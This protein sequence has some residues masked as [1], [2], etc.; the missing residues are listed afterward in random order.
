LSNA[1][2]TGSRD[3]SELKQR[4]GLKKG[5]AAAPTGPAPRTNGAGTTGG[6]VPPPGLN[7]PPPPGLAQPAQPVIP[8]AADDPFAAMNAMAAVGTVQRAPEIVIVNDG[9]PVEHVGASSKGAS[10]AR[11]AIPA[12]LALIVGLAIGKI[13][14]SASSYND[15]LKGA[16]AILGDKNTPSTVA[17]LKKQLSDLDTWLDEAKTKGNF[18]P[19]AQLDKELESLAQKLE[20]KT[21]LV[22]RAKQN[23]LDAETSGE[24]MSFYAGVSELKSMVDN[25]VKSAKSDDLAFANAAK[26][27]DAATVKDDENAALAGQLR[28]GILIQA[29]TD[30]D[31]VDFGAKLVELGPP[32]CGDKL[33]TSGKCGEGE[34]PSAFAYRSEP[35]ATWTKGDIV[36]SG[37][38]SVPTKKLVMLLPG[39]VRDSLVKGAEGVASETLYTKRLRAIYD[40]VH[41]KVGPDGKPVGGLLEQGNKLEQRLQQEASKSSRFS[42]FM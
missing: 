36:A 10:I 33:A 25:H 7:L 39:G 13:G 41:G 1:K 28:Y 26:K 12:G 6:V 9:K 8:N 3:I 18:R 27:A 17:N 2:K 37:A 35:G 4:L 16:R 20:V 19:N 21:E 38:D 11:L 14:T 30:T 32:Y 15:G 24:I 31:K 22:F 5:A 23:T 42:F 29:P 40:F 34:A